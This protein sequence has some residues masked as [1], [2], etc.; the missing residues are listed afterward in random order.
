VDLEPGAEKAF[1]TA[2]SAVQATLQGE[3]L[4][5]RMIAGGSAPR[6]VRLRPRPSLTAILD[7]KNELALPDAVID[8]IAKTTIE[9]LNLR[10]TMNYRLR[11]GYGGQAGLSPARQ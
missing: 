2:V 3:T 10:P 9:V 8:L 6:F 5:F 1:E 7:G 11:Q 4:W